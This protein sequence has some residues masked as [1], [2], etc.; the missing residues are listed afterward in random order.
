MV[1]ARFLGKLVADPAIFGEHLARRVEDSE[2]G[3]PYDFSP[4]QSGTALFLYERT[5]QLTAGRTF[6]CS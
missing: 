4:P 5:I 1:N 6:A 3:L 2:I